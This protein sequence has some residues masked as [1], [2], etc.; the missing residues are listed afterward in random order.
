MLQ[1][2]PRIGKSDVAG[3]KKARSPVGEQAALDERM[4][5]GLVGGAE[6]RRFLF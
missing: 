5:G 3:N 2:K 4:A 1:Q 6:D